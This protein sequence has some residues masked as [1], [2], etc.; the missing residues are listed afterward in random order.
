MPTYRYHLQ[1]YSPTSKKTC[2][3][4]GRSK[5]FT[6][7]VDADNRPAGDRFGI[8]DHA[9]CGYR[10][11]PTN[12]A[13]TLPPIVEKKANPVYYTKDDVKAYRKA[14]M[15]NN[16]CQF[17][18]PKFHTPYFDRVLRDYC[19]GSI[20][21]AIIFWQIDSHL[22]IHRGKVMYYN[23]DGHRVKLQRKDGSEYGRVKMMWNFLHR[24]RA[25]EPEMCY[26]GEHLVTLYPDKPVALVESEK[27]AMVMSYFFPWF[28]WI[29][30][31]S[32]NN[33]QSYRL[34]FL[35]DYRR[36]VIV[37][38]DFDGFDKWQDKAIAIKNL[39]P[40][41]LIFVDDFITQYGQGHDDIADLFIRHGY[42]IF[43]QFDTQMQLYFQA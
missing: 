7:Y 18:A 15:K 12:T 37:F 8:C 3:S 14:A 21:N 22:Q 11:Y 4:C 32:L 6:L 17:L 38:P 34:G 5:C 42:N 19:I 40:D 41:S 29:A 31:L 33:F 43:P 28:N 35:K 24:D 20:D 16:L 10:L 39:A 23:T 26:F 25:V 27:T 36:P 2:P 1:K 9:G 30:T 13:P